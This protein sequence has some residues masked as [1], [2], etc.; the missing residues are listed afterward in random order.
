MPPWQVGV[1]LGHILS[2]EDYESMALWETNNKDQPGVPVI[3]KRKLGTSGRPLV[4]DGPQHDHPVFFLEPILCIA[5][6]SLV[7]FRGVKATSCHQA[8]MGSSSSHWYIVGGVAPFMLTQ[9]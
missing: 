1:S 6:A 2:A 5:V 9:G 4:E 7:S 3:I 8:V